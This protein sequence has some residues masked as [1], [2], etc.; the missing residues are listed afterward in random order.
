MSLNARKEGE[1]TTMKKLNEAVGKIKT[2]EES[3]ESNL[4]S[5]NEQI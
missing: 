2:L 3:V 4:D 1:Q 5:H